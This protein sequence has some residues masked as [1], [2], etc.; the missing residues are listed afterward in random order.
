[1]A[2]PADWSIA[3][4]IRKSMTGLGISR[5]VAENVSECNYSCWFFSLVLDHSFFEKFTDNS[6]KNRCLRNS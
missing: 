1:M 4:G 3:E 6:A 2:N 5:L